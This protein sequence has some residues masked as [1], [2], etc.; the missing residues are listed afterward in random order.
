M[1]HR[2][3][4]LVI[5]AGIVAGAVG[6]FF[7][8][9][10]ILVELQAQISAAPRPA[11]PATTERSA[12]AAT[13]PVAATDTDQPTP[14]AQATRALARTG[15][16]A[17]AE[18]PQSPPALRLAAEPSAAPSAEAQGEPRL[19][20]PIRCT[21]GTDC[22]LVNYVDGDPTAEAQDYTCG[23]TTYDGHKGADFA[24]RD[25]AVM[26]QGVAVLAA[27]RGVVA[28]VRDGMKDVS[29]KVIGETAIKGREC[30]NGVLVR[31]Q[32]RWSTQYCHMR[33]GSVTVKKGD[34]VG[35]GQVLGMV[36]NSGKAEFPHLHIQVKKGTTVVDPFVG[37][38]RREECGL[39]LRPLWKPGVL[40]RLPYRP[41][42]IYNAG[43]AAAVP[44]PDKAR[45]GAYK[46]GVLPRTAP[47]LV[48]WADVFWVRPGD[49][50]AFRIVGPGGETVFDH[51]IKTDKILA[52][53]F[54]YAGLPRKGEKWPA[55]TYKGEIRLLRGKATTGPRQYTAR[56]TVIL[57]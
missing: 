2:P 30:G 6:L 33:Q 46:E 55:G 22:W 45:N 32:D 16:P 20:L 27:A 37:L 8:L 19:I 4:Q 17:A 54:A 50:L 56:T 42:A 43:F 44:S 28:G 7:F 47:N 21:P 18:A 53:R 52:R 13:E 31:H 48:L 41:S 11:V 5:T 10:D 36:G 49:K 1:T 9:G 26:R 3:L 51:E 25:L 15:P 29:F 12:G 35:A 39:G 23:K 40:A 57:R 14:S 34:R 24:I 38:T